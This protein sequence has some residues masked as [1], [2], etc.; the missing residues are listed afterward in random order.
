[1]QHNFIR[2]ITAQ[3]IIVVPEHC[4]HRVSAVFVSIGDMLDARRINR[5]PLVLLLH[6]EPY[7]FTVRSIFRALFF[8]IPD[9]SVEHLRV[10]VFLAYC[11]QNSEF[12]YACAFEHPLQVFGVVQSA[13]ILSV[14]IEGIDYRLDLL[15]AVG[16]LL[17]QLRYSLGFILSGIFD[18]LLEL[19]FSQNKLIQVR[20]GLLKQYILARFKIGQDIDRISPIG[21]LLCVIFEK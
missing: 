16:I 7:I 11:G 13:L 3:D 14:C 20:P 6:F 19:V 2:F 12:Q 18:F 21:I 10:A 8:K 5:N 17:L 9:V 15:S 4:Y 1:M